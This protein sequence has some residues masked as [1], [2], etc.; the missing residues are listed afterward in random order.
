MLGP[1]CLL[2]VVFFS[3]VVS[4]IAIGGKPLVL[5]VV[6][7]DELEREARVQISTPGCEDLGEL[8]FDL[9][10]DAELVFANA[11]D[12]I[13]LLAGAAVDFEAPRPGLLYISAITDRPMSG[14]GPL[15]ELHLE[16]Y[17]A[18]GGS[19]PIVLDDARARSHP[20]GAGGARE[21]P[22]EAGVGK[23]SLRALEGSWTTSAG[24]LLLAVAGIL[25]ALLVVAR[26]RGGASRTARKKE[27]GQ[28]SAD[29][30][31]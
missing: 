22:V 25:V 27:A 1:G 16:A 19:S 28:E 29:P 11:V 31:E 13:G 14:S 4:P 23:V 10:F 17:S 8:S 9:H 24:Y 30:R 2:L 5:E 3:L 7:I 21:I 18:E 6:T 15:L 20:L 12:G 26:I